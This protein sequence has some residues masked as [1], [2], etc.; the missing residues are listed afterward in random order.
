MTTESQQPHRTPGHATSSTPR[1]TT[2]RRAE[3]R[4]RLLAAGFAVFAQKGFGATR[5]EDVCEAAGYTR[6]AFYSNFS[7]LDELFYAI[8]QQRAAVISGQITA[9]LAGDNL[10]NSVRSILDALIVDRDWVLIKTDFLLYAARNPPVDREL[11]AHR[12]GLLDSVAGALSPLVDATRL[13]KTLRKPNDLAQ[14]V[15]ALYDG[16]MELLLLQPDMPHL[17]AWLADA[18]MAMLDDAHNQGQ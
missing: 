12:A 14:A 3:T 2:R 13:P 5:I 7:S 4:G 17:R 6:G 11:R 8:Y 1:R 10:Q 18:I 16:A 9:A 15:I